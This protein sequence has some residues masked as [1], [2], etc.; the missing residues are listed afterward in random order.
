MSEIEDQMCTFIAECGC[1]YYEVIYTDQTAGYK[2]V[3]C[4]KHKE[5]NR[6]L[7]SKRVAPAWPV[8]SD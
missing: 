5:A 4:P 2:S 6:M 8:P 3:Q 1:K 7:A